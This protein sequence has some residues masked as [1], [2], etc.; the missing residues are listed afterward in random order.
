MKQPQWITIGLAIVL[1]ATVFI[2]ARTVPEKKPVAQPGSLINNLEGGLS[3]DT[4]LLI[5]RQQLTPEQ[6]SRIATLENSI[7]RGAV[8][9]QQL[10]VYHQLAHFWGD[11]MGFF[12]P[13]AWYEAESARLENSEKSLTFAAHLFLN[14]LLTESSD[15]PRMIKWK[16]LQAKDLFERSLTINPGND[17]AKVGLGACYLF[18][19]ISSTPMEGINHIREAVARDSTNVYAQMMLVKGS[20]LSNQVDKAVARLNTVHRLQPDNVEALLLLGDIA[21][22]SGKN[23]EAANWYR[24]SLLYIRRPDYRA[25]IQKRITDL[26]K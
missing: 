14:S 23:A 22:K 10:S 3:T 15:D 16:A 6:S 13:Y 18:G 25:E 19:H 1:T 24:E 11:S 20:L 8:K 7:S 21:E 2:F 9:D 26:G 4:I 5:A 17:S 12:P